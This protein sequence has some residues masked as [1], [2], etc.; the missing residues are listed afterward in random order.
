MLTYKEKQC[1]HSKARYLCR[2]SLS[3]CNS[4]SNICNMQIT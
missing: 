1:F 4:F 3:L 2:F